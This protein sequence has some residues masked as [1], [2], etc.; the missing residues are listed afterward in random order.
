MKTCVSLLL[1]VILGFGCISTLARSKCDDSE[2]KRLEAAIKTLEEIDKDPTTPAGIKQRNLLTLQERRSELQVLIKSKIF[3]LQRYR[4]K[5]TADKST[6]A[7]EIKE[8]DDEIDCLKKALEGLTAEAV[9]KSGIQ[10]SR[11]AA[12]AKS[13]ATPE[14]ALAANP[15]PQPA[16]AGSLATTPSTSEASAEAAPVAAAGTGATSPAA[17]AV[18]SN[19]SGCSGFKNNPKVFSLAEKYACNL[20]S[21]VIDRKKKSYPEVFDARADL[22]SVALAAIA[23]KDRPNY[24]VEAEE[25]RVDKQLGAGPSGMGTTSLTVK[26]SGPQFLGLAVENGAL[27]QSV[28]STVVTFRGNPLGI[29]Q[30]LANKGYIESYDDAQKYALTRFFKKI[31]FSFSFD[32]SRGKE[33]V[34]T[35]SGT[36][37]VMQNVFTA[38]R[39]QLSEVTARYEIY[40]QRDPRS[41]RYQGDWESFLESAANRNLIEASYTLFTKLVGNGADGTVTIVQLDGTSTTPKFPG[42]TVVSHQELITNVQPPNLASVCVRRIASNGVSYDILPY[43]H[44]DPNPIDS[45]VGPV[46][47]RTLCGTVDP[48]SFKAPSKYANQFNDPVLEEWYEKT[49]DALQS[50]ADAQVEDVLKQQFEALPVDKLDP[51]TLAVMRSVSLN[52]EK[53]VSAKKEVVDKINRGGI[54]TFEYTNTRNVNAPNLSNFRLIAEKGAGGIFDGTFNGSVTIF[55]KIP[56]G[57]TSRLR[58]FQFSGQADAMLGSVAGVGSLVLS[59]SGRFERLMEDARTPDGMI[60][61]NTKGDIA[62]AQAKLTIPVKGTGFKIP[63]SFTVANRT[64]LIKEKEVRGN[65]GFTFDLDSL[66]SKFKP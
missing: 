60:V 35:T 9:G 27:A 57:M 31:S 36:P 45:T 10:D 47:T 12:E 6:F 40:N 66:F 54:V 22:F 65:I 23:K 32:T 21:S 16:G 49:Q 43:R 34:T 8:A 25:K 58:D 4:D 13:A 33:T 62:V 2:V 53:Y 24:L 14:P 55:D 48:R 51:Q 39:Q 50:A 5:L 18:Q 28:S 63:I 11:D 37:P 29:I 7:K 26:G 59:F 1:I 52:F 38:D 41:K 17:P 19:S 64:E 30:A 20:A 61:M 56:A 46:R 15:A 3:D 44:G 42:G